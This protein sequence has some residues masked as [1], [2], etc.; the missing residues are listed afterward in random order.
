MKKLLICIAVIFT[1]SANISAQSFT[2]ASYNVRQSNAGDD[3][4]GNG[5]QRRLPVIASLI[6]FHDFDI[7]GAQE[8]R[9]SQLED[10]LAALPGYGYTGV[11]RD[12]GAEAGE[13][14]VVFYKR[15]RFELL[16]SGHFWLSEE[17][18]RPTKGWDAKYVRICCWGQFLDRE[19][20]ERFWFFTLHTD[21]K[22]ERAQVES[23]RLVLDK[24]RTMCRGER[25]VLTGDFNVGETS[26]S[27]AVLRDSGLLSDTYDLAE[28]KYAWTGTENGF[29]P[30]RKTF[31]HIDYVFVTPGFRVLRYGI[32]TDTYRSEEPEGSA[33]PFRAR[34][35]SDHFP[36]KVQ[37]A[38][39]E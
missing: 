1:A 27:Y 22:G 39:T 33:K 34:T 23:C 12:D 24:I 30:D 26:G 9:H 38:F 10:L 32:L 13:Y 3:A 25:V 36:V 19:T 4:K 7:F 21:H 2:A 8:V 6:R 15:D 17:P 14:S 11:G 35:P 31:R 37:L 29:D 20:R 16:D 28:I 5:W 18:S